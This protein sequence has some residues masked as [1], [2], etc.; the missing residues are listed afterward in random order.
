M[1][2][3]KALGEFLVAMVD[4]GEWWHYMIRKSTP[5]GIFIWEDEAQFW[6]LKSKIIRKSLSFQ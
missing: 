2:R 3:G 4:E 6:R 5:S 1:G